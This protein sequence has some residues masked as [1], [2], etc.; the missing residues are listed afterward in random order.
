MRTAVAGLLVALGCAATVPAVELAMGGRAAK[1]TATAT[2][3]IG[4]NPAGQDTLVTVVRWTLA[5]DGKGGLDS[6]RVNTVA[7]MGGSLTAR[8][9][10]GSVE[11][12]F[13]QGIPYRDA[14]YD[15]GAQVCAYRRGK[16]TCAESAVTR[17]QIVDAAPP[18]PTV[19][20]APTV[21][22]VPL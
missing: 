9:P 8:P 21:V 12:T 15:I 11:V 7:L 14:Q 13:R 6:L 5:D 22:P 19:T 20:V 18:A 4:V 2:V 16:G 1:M 10:V 3:R 17:V